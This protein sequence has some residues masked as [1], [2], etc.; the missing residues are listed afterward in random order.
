MTIPVD[1]SVVAGAQPV[2]FQLDFSYDGDLD[3]SN[4]QITAGA[5]LPAG[6]SLSVNVNAAN[7]TAS[8]LGMQLLATP[9]VLTAGTIVNLQFDIAG[10]ALPGAKNVTVTNVIVNDAL[11]QALPSAATDGVITAR[12]SELTVGSVTTNAGGT[13]T[14]PVTV[15]LAPGVTPVGFQISLSF[16]ADLSTSSAQITGGAALPA[17]LSL[18]TSASGTTATILGVQFSRTPAA[19]VDGT[20]LNIEFDVAAGASVGDKAI[21]VTTVLLNDAA[22]QSIPATAVDGKVTVN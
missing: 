15:S 9:T 1:L 16:D 3:I 13:V 14:V 11:G 6:V 7:N 10:G 12:A 22:A 8:I 19:I 18:S 2:G 4:G 17:G 5:A 21:T 20:L